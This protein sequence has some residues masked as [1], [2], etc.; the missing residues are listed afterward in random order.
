[1][2]TIPSS[3]RVTVME[4][5]EDMRARVDAKL[6]NMSPRARASLSLAQR[7]N[8]FDPAKHGGEVMFNCVDSVSLLSTHDTAPNRA[9]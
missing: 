1:M 2:K 9:R 7:L 6:L 4:A 5:R 3:T 8:L